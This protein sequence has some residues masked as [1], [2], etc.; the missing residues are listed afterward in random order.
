[1]FVPGY[2]RQHPKTGIFWFRRVVPIEHRARIGK[3]EIIRSLKTRDRRQARREALRMALEVEEMLSGNLVPDEVT[4]YSRNVPLV[5]F[6]LA[7]LIEDAVAK[8][9]SMQTGSSTAVR[10]EPGVTLYEAFAAYNQ[11]RQLRTQSLSE[12]SSAIRRFREV[13]GDDL[14]VRAITK[15]HV[16]AFKDA[17]MRMPR[18]L[19]TA[20]RKL[21]LLKLL[22]KMEGREVER[23][24]MTT[25][26]KAM[27]IIHVVL[28]WCVKNGHLDVNPATGI[29]PAE[30]N[31]DREKRLPYDHNDISVIFSSPLY[32]GCVSEQCRW[33]LGSVV[34]RDACYWLPLLGL[35]SGCRLEELGQLSLTDIK[36]ED[37]IWYLDINTMDEGKSLKTKGSKRKV[38]LHPLV[39]DSGFITYVETMR[40]NGASQVFPELERNSPG[41]TTAAWSKW[42]GRYCS[43]IGLTDTRKVF[44]SFRHAFKDACRAAGIEEAIHDTLTGHAAPHVGRTYGK[45][46]PLKVLDEAVAKIE[47]GIKLIT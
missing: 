20:D 9:L 39:I 41:K 17:I 15:A 12:F 44:H 38:P 40:K 13:A 4:P 33:K 2:L 7:R 23:V 5:S 28:A 14:V 32:R 42:W 36:F 1:M 3:T 34:V 46:Y 25:V 26:R 21:P 45:G 16:R 47:F 19:S 31:R 43:Q 27:G 6:D 11:E 8:V 29:K 24:S 10:V 37:D 18:V 35:S 30:T 22:D